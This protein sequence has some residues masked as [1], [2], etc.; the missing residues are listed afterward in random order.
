MSKSERLINEFMGDVPRGVTSRYLN[1]QAVPQARWQSPD[2]IYNSDGLDYSPENPGK[3]IL[4]GAIG[5]KL[6]GIEDNRHILTVAG[7]RS[8]KSVSIIGNL[9]FYRGSVLATDP[10]GELANITALRRAEMGQNIYVLDP[11]NT[12]S[13]S[14]AHLRKSYN[15]LSVLKIDSPTII[16]DA[17]LIAD[18]LVIAAGKDPHWD[19][20]AKQY[21]EGIIDRKS[22]RLNSSHIP[23]SRMPSSA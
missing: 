21:I 6:V 15:P 12:V 9:L 14:I 11:F 10:K 4:V 16:E 23:L 17:G 18:A 19:E 3:K 22:T 5:D 20:S 2:D 8:G 13:E 1:Q 7:S